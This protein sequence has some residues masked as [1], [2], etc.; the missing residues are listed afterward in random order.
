MEL[1]ANDSRRTSGGGARQ[2]RLVVVECSFRSSEIRRLESSAMDMYVTP[3]FYFSC[4][5]H[6][7]QIGRESARLAATFGA[8]I[9]AANTTGEKTPQEGYRLPGTGDPDGR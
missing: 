9:L 3:I 4:R 6:V 5:A 7:R 1:S 2:T 8:T